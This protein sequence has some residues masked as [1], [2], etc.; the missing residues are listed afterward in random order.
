MKTLFTYFSGISRPGEKSFFK[1]ILHSG[2]WKLI[3]CL[4]ETSLFQYLKYPLH[5]KHI[6]Y[7]L[8]IYFKR[9]LCCSQWQSNFCLVETIFSHSHFW[10]ALLQL[11]GGRYF[12]KNLIS[13]RGNHFREIFSDTDWNGSCFLVQWNHIFQGILLSGKRKRIFALF[14]L[15]AFFRS[16]FLLVDNILEIRCKPVFFNFFM[17]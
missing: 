13:V 14:K 12:L 3:F 16:F 1:R 4:A 6:F 2:S 7:L 10:E 17:S 15:C 5:L 11:E 9:I 8:E